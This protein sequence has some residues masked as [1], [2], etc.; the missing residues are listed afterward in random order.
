[1]RARYAF[2]LAITAICA[3]S[4]A[5]AR[6]SEADARGL[7]VTFF[8]IKYFGLNGNPDGR[9]GQETRVESLKAH[10]AGKNLL[11]DVM[12]FEEIVDVALLTEQVLQNKYACQ[13]YDSPD[14]KHQHVVLCAKADKFRLS[15]DQGET[16]YLYNDLTMGGRVRPGV[17]ALVETADGKA[18]A[19][20]V[21]LHLK[22]QPDMSPMRTE[23]IKRL[24]AELRTRADDGVPTI[25]VGDM[26]TFNDDPAAFQAA[27]DA[28]GVPLKEIQNPATYTWRGNVNQGSKLDRA[29]ASSTARIV[30]GPVVTGPCNSDDRAAIQQYNRTVSDHCAVTVTLETR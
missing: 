3:W 20:V 6:A 17:H 23:Q 21:G 15:K 4:P 27:F 13:S 1:M 29:W 22:A 28:A 18:L 14:P 11:T 5:L 26:N 19:H 7:A 24:A 25:I 30:S 10:L 2:S 9:I 12:V 8:N 16:D